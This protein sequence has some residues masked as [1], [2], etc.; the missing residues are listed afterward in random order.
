SRETHLD[1]L[2]KK[3]KYEKRRKKLPCQKLLLFHNSSRTSCR[4]DRSHRDSQ[5]GLETAMVDQAQA[6]TTRIAPENR[7]LLAQEDMIYPSLDVGGA[8]AGRT[9]PELPRSRNVSR[10]RT[11]SGGSLCGKIA[12][13]YRSDSKMVFEEQLHDEAEED[14]ARSGS[15]QRSR[16][17]CGEESKTSEEGHQVSQTTSTTAP[18]AAPTLAFSLG[19]VVLYALSD[20]GKLITQ[21]WYVSSDPRLNVHSLNMTAKL[22]DVILSLLLAPLLYGCDFAFRELFNWQE[23]VANALPSLGLALTQALHMIQLFFVTAGETIIGQL[24]IPLTALASRYVLKKAYSWA[25][26]MPLIVITCA[27]LLFQ[28]TKLNVKRDEDQKNL[29]YGSCIGFASCLFAVLSFLYR[30]GLMKARNKTPFV[31]QNFQFNIT[32]VIWHLTLGLLV[33]PQV[34][35]LLCLFG[36]PKEGKTNDVFTYG[37]LFQCRSSWE[38]RFEDLKEHFDLLNNGEE[39]GFENLTEVYLKTRLSQA[40]S[41]VNEIQSRVHDLEHASNLSLR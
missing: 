5:S 25:Q 8:D 33:F 1:K 34:G 7:P 16:Y 13:P 15:R 35:K 2:T 19:L 12:A 9:S 39:G 18:T 32:M 6:S 24:R 41:S 27:V 14:D 20:T 10:T 31:I 29:L 22:F 28:L 3:C 38:T 26:W 36:K 40:A 17:D 4:M 30:E 21:S 23:I 37:A 11:M